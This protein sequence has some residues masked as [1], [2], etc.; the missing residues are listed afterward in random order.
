MRSLLFLS[1][2]MGHFARHLA[3]PRV[4]GALLWL[5]CA[6]GAGEVPRAWDEAALAQWATPLAGLNARPSHISSSE[7]Y[8]LKVDNLRTYPVYMP[9]SEPKGYW[10]MLQHI[11]PKALIEPVGLKSKAD[12]IEAG[13]LVFEQIDHVHLRTRDPKL[14]AAVRRGESIVPGPG[15]QAMNLRWV[16]TSEGLALSAVNC[17]NCHR[18]LLQDGTVIPG[19]PALAAPRVPPPGP[20]I[21]LVVQAEK[22]Y[23]GGAAPIRF[24]SDSPGMRLYR[25]FGVPWLKDD[26]HASW[27]DLSPAQIEKMVGAVVRGGGTPRWNGSLEYTAKIPDLI[28]VAERKYIDHT[29]THL[30]RGIADLMRY[31][32]MVTS[33]EPGVFGPHN[34][35][36]GDAE[37]VSVRHSDEML[38]ALALYLGSLQPP[39]NPN[40]LNELAR[41]GG[42]VF[43]REGCPAC[44]T[45]PLYTNNKVTLATGFQ[46]PEDLPATLD[47]LPISVGTD[48]GLALKTR[49]GT[50]FYKV[51]SLK[52]VW[53]RGHYLHDG[54]VATLEEMF[55]PERLK[56]AHVPGGFLAAGRKS[57]AIIGHEFGL[58]LK[59]DERAALIA[60]LRTL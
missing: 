41:A 38:Y 50:G 21:V 60:F 46:P 10:E 18:A 31:A 16:P 59:P 13:R 55:D 36:P 57:K 43:D 22:L 42:K 19:A 30:N 14:I 34:V 32:A 54:S 17:A 15:G 44:H 3:M 2:L 1:N 27:K 28:G 5:S 45:P 33:A 8:A 9:G 53:Y 58:R 51:P 11:G 24:P 37:R 35:L 47:V 56:D 23:P 48:P 52:G 7:Y 29:A 6:I 25:A 26:I 20:N 4:L 12:W 39:R 49:K 40:P